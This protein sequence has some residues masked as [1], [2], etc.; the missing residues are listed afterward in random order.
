MEYQRQIN[1][2]NSSNSFRVQMKIRKRSLK[3]KTLYFLRLSSEQPPPKK[4]KK[5]NSMSLFF[6]RSSDTWFTPGTRLLLASFRLK[7]QKNEVCYNVYTLYI[8][9]TLFLH[10]LIS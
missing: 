4:N 3:K 6:W 2:S 1:V 7:T 8:I 9:F 5:K 10:F